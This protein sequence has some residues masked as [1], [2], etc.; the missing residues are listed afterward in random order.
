MAQ[1]LGGVPGTS[2]QLRLRRRIRLARLIIAWERLWPLLWP[3]PAL[4]ALFCGL[5]LLDVLPLLPGWLHGGVL[6][7]L[8]G[9]GLVCGWRLKAF[10]LPSEEEGR[11][12]IEEDSGLAHRPLQLLA[13]RLAAGS[14]D[15]V[16]QALWQAEH[17]R[18]QGV[19]TR[20]SLRPPSPGV[21]R[22]DPLG[23][24]F[25]APMLLLVALTGGWPDAPARF[26]RA[27]TP[28]VLGAA[29]PAP[30]L[31]VWLTPPAYTGI[32]P[33]LLQT[34]S[35][36][37]R[38][39]VP[40]GSKLL[41]ELQGGR[42]PAQLAIDNEAK[43]FEAL[44]VGSQR[45]ETTIT[46]GS[47]LVIRQGRR[48]VG[49][50]SIAVVVD[51]PPTISF[52][53]PPQ[54]DSEGRLRLDIEAHD[55]YG[56]TKA[57]V[58]IRRL[59]SPQAEPLLVNLPLGGS[60][61]ADVHQ[62]SVHDLTGHPWAGL[63]VSLQPVAQDA[64]GQ[65]GTGD[66]INMTLPERRFTNP[67]ARAIIE[68]RRKLSGDP[69]DRRPVIDGLIDIASKIDAYGGDVITFL[70]LSDSTSR[71]HHDHS[72]AAVPSVL[73]TLWQTA[74][75]LEE[76]DRP[77]AKLALD[78]A[79]RRLEEAMAKGAS[80]A[81]LEQLMN[82]LQQAM[83]QYLDALARQAE[84]Q[85]AM[86]PQ[87]PDQQVISS[88]ELQDMVER[89]RE[90]SRTGSRQAAQDMLAQLRQLLDN[91]KL[92]NVDQ[93]SAEQMEQADRAMSELNALTRDQQS[94]LDETFRRSQ[95]GMPQLGPPG[96]GD[97]PLLRQSRPFSSNPPQSSM[98]GAASK[99]R[100]QAGQPHR[101]KDDAQPGAAERQ[102]ALR[103]RLGQV[104]QSLGDLGAELPDSLGQAEQAMRDS[105]QGLQMGDMQQSVD[106]QTEAV[107]RLQEGARQAMKSLAQQ[108]G[109][110]NVVRSRGSNPGR[111][112]LGR[113]LSGP[114]RLDENG[115]KIPDQAD[116]KKAREV[117]DELRR[118]SGQAE[119]P[120][121][122]RE[123]LQR[124]LK[125]FF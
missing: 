85:G 42:G 117:L 77:A 12:R 31:Q 80:D 108:M 15:A 82:Q 106:S 59:D 65:T 17:R 112:P 1:E 83:A 43:P 116:V 2:L 34:L 61:P 103:K 122:E 28:H 30:V 90:M 95:E 49:A 22:H 24:R 93:G 38:V 81:E 52:A 37:Q 46:K 64:A 102:E 109:G 16:S 3:L 33:M 120:P 26:L 7:A 60:H 39:S 91:L 54:A 114:G 110:G 86:P 66:A 29:E 98:P 97:D 8:I 71:L 13:D 89:M 41:A 47:Q 36:E 99:G 51:R 21:A 125:Q 27:V 107:A 56:V 70:S 92:G 100:P 40:A 45:L 9:T 69:T 76:G 35:P 75:R 53:A 18:L 84:R 48:R 105:T 72:E 68:Q 14:D 25:A 6:A 104:M 87:D 78:E 94:L 73:D 44:D 115:V 55:D 20:L 96:D 32:A 124:L 4:V 11:H 74:L 50:W 101:G 10:R 119:R 5:A 67:V 79:A 118:R 63:K 123:Y 58:A 113:Q 121:A 19:L 62:A 23:L 111:D 88:D 57:W